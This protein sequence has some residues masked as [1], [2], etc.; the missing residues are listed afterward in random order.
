MRPAAA[1]TILDAS[2]LLALP[3]SIYGQVLIEMSVREH[4]PLVIPAASLY[5][6]AL[7]GADPADFDAA[8]FTVIALS[9]AIVPGLV[10]L[11]RSALAHIGPELAHIAW[12]A[13]ATGYPVLT[14]NAAPYRDLAAPPDLEIL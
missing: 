3:R 9:Q 10:L 1:G 5:T 14:A 8:G 2:A 11:G 4:R 12:E 6:A 7:A 13:R